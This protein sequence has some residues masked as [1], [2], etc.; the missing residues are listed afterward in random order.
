MKQSRYAGL[1]LLYQP[2][3]IF[4]SKPASGGALSSE[5]FFADDRNARKH[6]HDGQ[7]HQQP[8]YEVLHVRA[9][10]RRRKRAAGDSEHD[11]YQ[12]VENALLLFQL[13]R[14]PQQIEHLRVVINP[15]AVLC[16]IS[17]GSVMDSA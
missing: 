9:A 1:I 17:S 5:K 2:I 6:F 3:V 14:A 11:Q 15:H 12:T 10:G 13:L 4:S 16:R 7:P 8:R